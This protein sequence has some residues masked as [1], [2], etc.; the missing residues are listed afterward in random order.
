MSSSDVIFPPPDI[1][2]VIDKTAEFVVKNDD[3]KF[4][5]KVLEQAGQPKFAFVNPSNPYR[6]YYDLRL[7][8]LREGLGKLFECSLNMI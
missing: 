8:E 7:K 3:G 6:K 1:K 2:S 4:E 5:R